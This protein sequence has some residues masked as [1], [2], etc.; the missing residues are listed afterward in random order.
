MNFASLYPEH[1][2][3]IVIDGVADMNDHYTGENFGQ[4]VK[5][6]AAVENS[7]LVVTKNVI[8]ASSASQ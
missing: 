5:M 6:D 3:R 1:V 7:S 4:F 8:L 2:G